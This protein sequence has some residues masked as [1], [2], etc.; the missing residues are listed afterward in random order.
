V[1][2]SVIKVTGPLKTRFSLQQNR[3]YAEHVGP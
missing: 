1:K 2:E 3:R